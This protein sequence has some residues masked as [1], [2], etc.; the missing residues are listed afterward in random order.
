MQTRSSNENSVRLSDRL[1]VSQTRELLQ[2][3]KKSVQIFIPYEK[4]FGLVFWEKEWWVR[5]TPS[6][7]NVGST[8]LRWSEIADF[9][10]IIARNASAVTSSEKSSI[11]TNRKSATRFPMRLRSSSY[12]VFRSTKGVQKCKTIDFRIKSNFVEESLQ[13]SFFL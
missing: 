6:T 7:W 4:Q 2:N 8:G 1:S 12:V 5:A 10:P 11:N 9:K 13:Q 3:E